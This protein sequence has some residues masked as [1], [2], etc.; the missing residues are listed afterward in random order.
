[1][2]SILLRARLPLSWEDL[3][4]VG[5]FFGEVLVEAFVLHLELLDFV[6][7]SLVFRFELADALGLALGELGELLDLFFDLFF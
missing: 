7:K 6:L 4:L 2:R 5:C 3:R 1:M